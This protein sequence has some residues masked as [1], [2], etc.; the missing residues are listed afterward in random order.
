M[1]V[2][3]VTAALRPQLALLREAGQSLTRATVGLTP[4]IVV[5]DDAQP[6]EL[7]AVTATLEPV[8][9]GSTISLTVLPLPF[10]AGAGGA[11][12]VGLSH[13]LTRWFCVLDADD[14]LPDGSLDTQLILLRSSPAARWCLGAGETLHQDGSRV[15]WSHELPSTVERGALARIT[16]ATGVM[17]TIPIAAIWDADLVRAL[18][19]WQSLPRDEDTGLK[20]AATTIASG[21]STP[22]STYV[23]RRDVPGALTSSASFADAGHWCRQVAVARLRALC[24]DDVDLEDIPTGDWSLFLNS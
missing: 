9:A 18:G 23:Y 3:V 19:G 20:L 17:P 6:G 4:W 22:L 10:R 14:L 15:L 24:C 13:V 2:S 21:V 11:R 1:G 16:M 7:A 8:L 5:L 12:S